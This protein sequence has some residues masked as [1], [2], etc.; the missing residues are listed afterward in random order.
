MLLKGVQRRDRQ[1]PVNSLFFSRTTWIHWHQ[2][3]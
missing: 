2:E 1:T 3:G